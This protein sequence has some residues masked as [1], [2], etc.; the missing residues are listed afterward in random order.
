MEQ[1]IKNQKSKHFKVNAETG[2]QFR[3]VAEILNINSA[4]L[5]ENLMCNYIASVK[6]EIKNI[7][8][9]YPSFS[10]KYPF[11]DP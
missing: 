8:N 5:L 3:A 1:R 11:I 4:D 9:K 2:I 6:K 10:E 7:A